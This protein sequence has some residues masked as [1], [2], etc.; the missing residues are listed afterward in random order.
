MNAKESQK[1]ILIL[2]FLLRNKLSLFCFFIFSLIYLWSYAIIPFHDHDSVI[3]ALRGKMI[4]EGV[5]LEFLPFDH[6]PLGINFIYGIFG[7]LVQYGHGQSL[8]ISLFFNALMIAV[9]Y[10]LLNSL[11]EKKEFSERLILISL[12]IFLIV[13]QAPFV[14]LSGNSETLANFFILTSLF[15]LFRATQKEIMTP[16]L[17]SSFFA[18]TSLSINYLSAVILSLPTLYLL[19][20]F[21]EKRIMAFFVYCIGIVIS[22]SAFMFLII[23][24]GDA[25]S[26]LD[27]LVSFFQIYGDR[28]QE[29]RM[30]SF[31]YFFRGLIIFIPIL[32]S[33]IFILSKI[34]NKLSVLVYTLLLWS[35]TAFVACLI[36]GNDLVHYLSFLVA[37]LIILST[38]VF[39]NLDIQ[40]RSLVF[41]VPLFYCMTFMATEI[42][43]NYRKYRIFEMVAP[44][45]DKISEIIQED[46]L[47]SIRIG[48]VPFY[49]AEIQPTQKY[50]FPEYASF[51]EGSKEDSYWNKSLKDYNFAI[52]PK[53]ICL[54]KELPLTCRSLNN[55]FEVVFQSNDLE[56]Y[57]PSF[58]DSFV[59]YKKN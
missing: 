35:V 11:T 33:S 27:D 59:L 17:I 1:I 40:Q 56:L 5:S 9:S 45:M 10:Y 42:F 3:Y 50:P 26:Y 8:I 28:T 6:K 47:I 14:G 19:M 39:I 53:G 54:I 52:V 25:K 16:V 34:S 37:P 13:F 24:S 51:F 58:V 30:K 49:L 18:I 7:Q 32:I 20:H 48:H 2:N 22:L 29:E 44:N 55:S 38:I 12:I 21:K 43:D 41:F 57:G 4:M 23:N 36:S 31:L 46:N 15:L